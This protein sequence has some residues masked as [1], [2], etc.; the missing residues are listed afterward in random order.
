MNKKILSIAVL[1]IIF[2]GGIYWWNSTRPQRM[3]RPN[4]DFVADEIILPSEEEVRQAAESAGSSA[5]TTN[6]VT[7]TPEEIEEAA[8]PR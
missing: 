8:K 7:A 2:A 6:Q 1:G 4:P 5:S 3:A